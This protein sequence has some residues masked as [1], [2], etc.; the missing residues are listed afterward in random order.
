MRGGQIDERCPV[1]VR[2]ASMTQRWDSLTF[3]H[4]EY[5]PAD[6][7]RLLPA[8]LQPHCF[9]GAAWVSLVPF[10]MQRVRLT[11]LPP[12]PTTYRFCETNVRTYV[13]APGGRTGVFFFSLDVPS[14]LVAATARRA[15]GLPYHRARMSIERHGERT[16]YRAAR[17]VG[18]A[19]AT[20]HLVAHAGPPIDAD[21]LDR[22]LTARWSVLRTDRRGG[23]HATA[24]EHDPWPLRRCEVEALDDSLVAAAGLPAP[25][26]G[27][28][29]RW[30]DGV[31]VRI[32]FPRRVGA[33][34]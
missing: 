30:S 8:P 16:T 9:D 34:G 33:P 18:A 25:Q 6:V 29:A 31:H 12:I 3:V 27:M 2:R 22:F 17:R 24:V 28:V 26:H 20:S 14:P 5:E 7:A 32:G 23:V 10:E 11:G 1:P 15:F 13:V 21:P 19:A 4:F